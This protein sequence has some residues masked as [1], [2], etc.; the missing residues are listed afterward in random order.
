MDQKTYK[1]RLN[2]TIII[3]IILSVY[4]ATGSLYEAG[5]YW[6]PVNSSVGYV[7]EKENNIN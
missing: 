6:K 1:M 5:T 2:K 3:T 4:L 7:L